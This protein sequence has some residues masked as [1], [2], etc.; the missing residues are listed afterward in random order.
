MKTKR[1][2]LLNWSNYPS[3]RTINNN[4]WKY[5]NVLFSNQNVESA[6]VAE[7]VKAPA[8]KAGVLRDIRVRDSVSSESLGQGAYINKEL[9]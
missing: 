6:L 8:S 5:I 1:K 9:K 3:L 2:K 4:A 7:L